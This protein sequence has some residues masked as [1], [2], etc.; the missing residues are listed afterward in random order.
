MYSQE[1]TVEIRGKISH[2][3]FVNSKNG[4]TVAE[5]DAEKIDFIAVGIMPPLNIGDEAMFTGNWVDHKDYGLQLKVKEI[6]I[7]LPTSEA[8]IKAYLASGAISGIGP[9]LAGRMVQK[10]GQD[11]LKIVANSPQELAQVKGISAKKAQTIAESFRAARS[12]QDLALLLAPLGVGNARIQKIY[13]ELGDNAVSLIRN[14]P[15]RLVGLIEGIAFETAD[16]LAGKLGFLA[17]R[18]ERVQAASFHLLKLMQRKGD[19]WMPRDDLIYG[20][21]RLLSLKENAIREIWQNEK[22]LFDHLDEFQAA[23]KVLVC[24]AESWEMASFTRE[25]I[26]RLLAQAGSFDPGKKDLLKREIEAVAESLALRLGDEQQM[27]L[28]MAVRKSFSIL[29]GGPGTGKTT[30][31]KVLVQY[32]QEQ[33]LKVLLAAPT[34]RAARR[35]SEASGLEAKTL[36][37]LL[38]LTPYDEEAHR[39]SF[40]QQEELEGDFLIVDE[41]SMLDLAVFSSLLAA[42]PLNMGLLLIGDSDQLPSI[43]AGQIL[44]DL[45]A[46]KSIPRTVL[47]KIY[48]QEEGDLIVKNAHQIRLGKSLLLEQTIESSFLLLLQENDQEIATAV[49]KLV[50]DILPR[51]YMLNSEDELQV[52]SA[53]RRGVAGTN[54]LNKSLQIIAQGKADFLALQRHNRFALGDKIIQTRN[55]YNLPYRQVDDGSQRQGVMNGERGLVTEIDFKEKTL[56]ILFEEER[57]VE[58]KDEAFEDIEL[59]YAITIHKS[60]GSEYENVILAIPNGAPDFLTRNLLYTGVTRAS[61]R[62]F[63]VCSRANLKMM[64]RN[65]RAL[66]RRT[67]LGGL[68]NQ[69]PLFQKADLLAEK[70]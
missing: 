10:F 35:L 42:L 27:A 30:I 12:W 18:P 5:V 51:H 14:N 25:K 68:L 23:D 61:R 45:L 36:H 57:L 43:G 32:L 6:K 53:T 20:L 60:Q 58:I 16:K 52:L 56:Q 15:Y 2:I 8:A 29:T 49:E 44:R 21:S 55:N 69:P 54:A 7:N 24:L 66:N 1:E 4:F 67:L 64:L 62:L 59:A 17:D 11:T 3:T 41:S 46:Q 28:E 38:S 22:E 19:I 70:I 50:T 40:W 63:L 37:R 9:V 65:E 39:L 34:G 48:R 31:I 13:R 26:L 47:K 33:G